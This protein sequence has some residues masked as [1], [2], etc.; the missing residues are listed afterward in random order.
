MILSVIFDLDG[1]LANT[2][3]DITEAAN[4]AMRKFGMP[5]HTAEEYKYF[6]GDGIKELI[7]RAVPETDKGDEEKVS[8]CLDAFRQYYRENYCVYTKPYDGIY[9]TLDKL[10][11]V[12]IVLGVVTNKN[13][14][15]VKLIVA[16]LF[17]GYFDIVIGNSDRVKQKPD[18]ESVNEIMAQYHLTPDE[19]V[20]VGDSYTDIRTAKNAGIK[21]VGVLWGFRTRKELEDE[22]ADFVISEP[23]DLLAII[24]RL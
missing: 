6:V 15:A 22:G 7:E 5:E 14:E 1:T 19:V 9:E 8:A 11:R 16:K 20:F 23:T 10:K 18:P 21:G 3:Q 2:I 13:E 12:G 17:K 24:D 4:F